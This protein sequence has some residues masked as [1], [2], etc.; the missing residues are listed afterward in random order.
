METDPTEIRSD[1]HHPAANSAYRWLKGFMVSNPEDYVRYKM[2]MSMAA[3]SGNR[4]AQICV[5]TIC[6][7]ANGEPVSDRYLLGLSWTIL[8]IHNHGMLEAVADKRLD[9][10][11][12][13]SE[14][15]FRMEES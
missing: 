12:G 5:G 1:E 3:E 13:P 8:S 10:A 6:R 2:A 11:Y 7:L 14:D 15:E 4:Q 9:R